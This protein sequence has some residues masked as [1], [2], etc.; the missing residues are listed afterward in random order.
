MNLYKVFAKNFFLGI[1]VFVSPLSFSNPSKDKCK[2]LFSGKEKSGAEGFEHISTILDKRMSEITTNYEKKNNPPEQLSLF[3][4][5]P[6]SSAQKNKSNKQKP[7]PSS[8]VSSQAISLELGLNVDKDSNI[9]N[10]SLHIKLQ[11]KDLEYQFSS[12]E[13][14]QDNK[15]VTQTESSPQKKQTEQKLTRK[16][17]KELAEKNLLQA[18]EE[19]N[20]QEMGNLVQEFEHLK[21]I[22]IEDSTFIENNVDKDHRHWCPKGWGLLHLAVYRQDLE[23]LDWLLNA[24]FNVRTK[25]KTG[26]VSVEHNPLHIAIRRGFI[27]EAKHILTHTK[28]YTPGKRK[29]H[30]IDEKNQ[31]TK[32]PWALAVEQDSQH[33]R[34][35]GLLFTPLIAKYKPSG[36]VESYYPGEGLKD[37]YEIASA[38]GSVTIM[39]LAKKHLRA[40]N[41]KEYKEIR[42]KGSDRRRTQPP[43]YY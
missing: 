38:S 19:R 40:K 23:M 9:E 34:S 13:L 14:S 17:K 6:L 27:E 30:F 25:K 8:S 1:F 37:G 31:E 12:M 20:F 26:A 7:A 39:D 35:E 36:H 28:T 10:L 16:E 18:F 22:R 32:T 2:D 43:S 3:E 33:Y 5:L 24:G 4:S 41:Y 29:G 11:D 21:N 42:N 15:K